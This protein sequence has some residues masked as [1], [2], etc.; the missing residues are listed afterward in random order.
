MLGDRDA[1]APCALS[2]RKSNGTSME[3]PYAQRQD[4]LDARLHHVAVLLGE[5]SHRPANTE[6]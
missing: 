3:P 5:L 6:L 2:P 4:S 1:N